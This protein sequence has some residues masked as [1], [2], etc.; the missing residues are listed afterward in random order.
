MDE[1]LEEHDHK[2]SAS[3]IRLR[4]DL[5]I[6]LICCVFIVNRYRYVCVSRF[7]QCR[8][9]RKL[10]NTKNSKEIQKAMP[11]QVPEKLGL[12]RHCMIATSDT[13]KSN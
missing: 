4:T 1:G 9:L 3:V 12:F 10:Y 2:S 5:R 8:K 11:V 6:K 13:Q 7:K